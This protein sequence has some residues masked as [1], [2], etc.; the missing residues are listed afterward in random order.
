MNNDNPLPCRHI[1]KFIHVEDQY[2]IDAY[3]ECAHCHKQQ[4]YEPE[5]LADMEQEMN[6]E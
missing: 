1:W 6:Y 4:P 3:F 2:G 5:E